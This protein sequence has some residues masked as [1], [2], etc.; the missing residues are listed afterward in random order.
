MTN[1]DKAAENFMRGCNCAQAVLLT[2]APKLGLSE[3]DA[4]HMA[5][6]FGGGMGHLRETCGAVTAMFLIAG[7]VRG[8]D[9]VEDSS[10]KREHYNL[11][12]QLA[13][14]FNEKYGTINCGEL[15]RETKNTLTPAERTKEYY[16]V[17]PC[18]RFVRT[19]ADIIDEVLF[20]GPT[21][22]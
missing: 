9:N 4:L 3:K 19:A 14:K 16:K 8:Y 22:G 15:L 13:A 11:I 10:Y 21:A 20:D 18:V 7:M 5:S 12:Q 6:S 1:A 2:Y 17:R